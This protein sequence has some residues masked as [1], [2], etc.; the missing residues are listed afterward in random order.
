MKTIKYLIVSVCL[1]GGLSACNDFFDTIPNDQLS[2]VTFWKTEADVINAVTACY[3]NWNN[4]ATGSSDIFFADCMSD[5]SY[6]FTGS[7]SYKNVSNGSSSSTST[8]GYYSY[9]TIRRCNLVLENAGQVLFADEAK[10]KDLVAQ[11]RTIRAWRY[12]QM[13][14]WY[15]GIPLITGLPELAED[16]QLPRSSE[17]DVK[18]F[19]YDELDVAIADL[20]KRPE[21][22]GRI[23][24]GTAL[25]IK[26]RASL[27]WGD[28]D[29][30]MEAARDIQNLDLYKLDPDFLTMFSEAGVDSD[31]IICAMQH[32]K[33][34]YAFDNAVR[35]FNNQDGG[36]ASW[37]PTQ[38]F[39]D[40]YEMNNGQTIDEEGSGY[41]P[42]HPFYN[43]DPRLYKTVI[44]P[45]MD[46][47]SPAGVKR[48]FNTLDKK[49]G[50][51]A[52]ADFMDAATNASH[53][54]LLWAKYILP[55]TQ[56]SPSLSNAAICP[57]L[58][59]YAEVL[60][61][62]AEINVEKNENT[63]EVFDILD[64]LRTTRG[65]IVVDRNKY[66]TQDKLRELVRRERC[67][68]LAGEGL[69]RADLLRWKDTTGKPLAETIM[70]QTLYR[71]S[72]TVD[73]KE[74]DPTRRAV[75][76]LPT[77][78]NEK[79]RKL[80]QLKYEPYN[81]YLPFTQTELDRNPNLKQNEGY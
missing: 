9:T 70:N 72:G 15:G 16:A 68:E 62:I 50:E 19:V 46:F 21:E 28:L 42:V 30:A 34:T 53:T 38:N 59:R 14:F 41:D 22:R 35:M 51:S 80:E 26:M 65:H 43:R 20:N 49:I 29:Q 25:A 77:A 81:R 45:G 61:T 37:V 69:R 6:S 75:V 73:M 2:P 10:K 31:E 55:T 58:F 3:E 47:T 64:E 79:F 24:K 60:L 44:Y 76:E 67:I 27:Y 48:I 33:D 63:E 1:C 17:D 39:V 78:E 36:W 18:K 71:I 32:V 4:P 66:N 52:N 57:I 12:F 7:S 40:M 8:V 23:A 13:N 54:G 56:F 5:I 11:V 74:T